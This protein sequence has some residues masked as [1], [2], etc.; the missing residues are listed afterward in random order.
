M[1]SVRS[2]GITFAILGVAFLVVALL[3]WSRNQDHA[4]DIGIDD[5]YLVMGTEHFIFIPVLFFGLMAAVYLLLKGLSPLLGK[6]H[7]TASMI[8]LLGYCLPFIGFWATSLNNSAPRRYY[9]YDGPDPFVGPV[10][11]LHDLSTVL[12]V[13]GALGQLFL[14]VNIVRSRMSKPVLE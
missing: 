6:L 7:L 2:I 1:R 10:I 5:S 11:Y 4:L 12:I 9:S 8:L 3:P 14:L 13:I